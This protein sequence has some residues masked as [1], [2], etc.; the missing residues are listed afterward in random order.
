MNKD[1]G[2]GEAQAFRESAVGIPVLAE[3]PQDEEIRRK[4]ANYEIIGKPGGKWAPL[5]EALGANEASAPPMRP[6]PLDHDGLL[7]L[8]KSEDVGR[9]VQLQPASF[10]DMC[11][12]EYTPRPSLEV[13]YEGA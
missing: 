8:F 7:D 13:R 4:S 1:D 9:D 10:E 11:G 6:S 3:V 5:F 2:T 12:V